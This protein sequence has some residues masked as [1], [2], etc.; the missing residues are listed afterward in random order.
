MAKKQ[1]FNP[2]VPSS[3]PQETV[4]TTNGSSRQELNEK[5][6]QA[7]D[8]ATLSD[9]VTISFAELLYYKSVTYNFLAPR[10]TL[11]AHLLGQHNSSQLGRG[12]I[13]SEVRQYQAGDDVRSIDWRVTARTGKTHTKLYSEERERPVILFVDLSQT[14]FFGS[15]LQLKAVQA[16]HMA[17]LIAWLSAAQ[18]DRIGAVVY[19]GDQLIELKPRAGIKGALLILQRLM[20]LHNEQLSRLQQQGLP[21]AKLSSDEIFHTIRRLAPKGSD[22][23]FLSDFLSID[24][25]AYEL[26]A[27]LSRHNLVHCIQI[28]DWLEQGLTSYK[29]GIYASDGKASRWFDFGSDKTTRSFADDFKQ[30]AHQLEQACLSYRISYA[31]L[32]ANRLL[33]E[34]LSESKP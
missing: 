2:F 14:M 28:Y 33:T 22:I 34:Q 32:S 17:T 7:L 21:T 27:M 1:S 3:Q 5:S 12:M 19:L 9:G 31:Q 20:T 29:G 25:N 23:V 18:K 26:F 30:R 24:P 13:F 16:V 15:T 8:C 6:A 4:S 11:W 10:R